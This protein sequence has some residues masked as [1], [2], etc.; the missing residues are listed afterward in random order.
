[1]GQSVIKT[2]RVVV[3]MVL[4]MAAP[5]PAT[6]NLISNPSFE[7][8]GFDPGCSGTACNTNF[9]Y[10]DDGDT[11]IAGWT[12]A[13]TQS[14]GEPPYWYHALRHPVFAGSFALALTDGS[15]AST[16]VAVEAG[17]R[18]RITFVGFRDINPPVSSFA[19]SVSLGTSQVTVE[20]SAATDTGVPVD[21]SQNWFR[22]EVELQASTTGTAS[23][24]IENLPD[25]ITSPDGGI[26]IDVVEVERAVTRSEC[27]IDG[28]GAVSVTDGVNV[29][30]AA[31]GLPSTCTAE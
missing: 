30:R 22:Y 29:L 10:L 6:A 9:Q 8:P 19:V 17:Q 14:N 24:A 13:R 26:A 18:Y 27:D 11:R 7:N 1:M 21:G 28:N 4:L 16:S 15:R 20:P 25:G 3:A 23:L 12:I 5:A 2:L 31:A